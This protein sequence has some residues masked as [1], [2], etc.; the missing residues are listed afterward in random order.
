[1]SLQ[2][3]PETCTRNIFMSVQMAYCDFAPAT[4]PWYMLPQCIYTSFFVAIT[5]VAVTC[6]CNSS[7]LPTFSKRLARFPFLLVSRTRPG[8]DAANLRQTV[9]GSRLTLGARSEA[10]K[11][12]RTN[13]R[14]INV[15]VFTVSRFHSLQKTKQELAKKSDILRKESP[16]RSGATAQVSPVF[17]GYRPQ[18]KLLSFIPFFIVMTAP[19][20]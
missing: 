2:H 18:I 19:C 9:V 5:Y 14:S 13:S 16:T 3:I 11:N 6:P 8:I 17:S 12:F 1:M 15:P 4:R 7:C 20:A 10:P